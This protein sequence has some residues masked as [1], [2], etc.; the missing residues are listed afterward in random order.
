M[1]LSAYLAH[2]AERLNDQAGFRFLSQFLT[3]AMVA[4]ALAAA[5]FVPGS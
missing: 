3:A 4:L 1:R 2:R 5:L